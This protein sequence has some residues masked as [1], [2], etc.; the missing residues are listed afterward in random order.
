MTPTSRSRPPSGRDRAVAATARE[1]ASSCLAVR[2]RVLSRAVTAIYEETLRPHGLKLTQLNLLVAIATVPG[3]APGEL[4]RALALEKSSLSRA[5]DV[6]RAS[7][8]VRVASG[9]D[10]RSQALELSSRGAELLRSTLP[11]WRR[12]QER[13]RELLGPDGDEALRAL[14]ARVRRGTS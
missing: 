12:A 6:L 8:W 13:A 11:A 2:V 4:S 3:I 9:P 1:I 5:V 7:G 14:V 10:G